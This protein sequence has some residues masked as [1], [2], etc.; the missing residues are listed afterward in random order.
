MRFD[1]V[2]LRLFVHLANTLNLTRAAERSH[3]SLS[4]ASA[5]IKHLE[6]NV[7][8]K[9]IYRHNLGVTLTPQGETFLQHARQI[10]QQCEQLN[11]DMQEY[12]RGMKGHLRLYA[13]MNASAAFVPDLLRQLLEKHPRISIDLQER[14][15][16]QEIIEAVTNGLADVGLL[17]SGLHTGNLEVLSYRPDPIVVAVPKG[18]RF[19]SRQMIAFE[20]AL[21]ED[22]IALPGNRFIDAFLRSHGCEKRMRIRVA[23]GSYDTVCRLIERNV[24]IGVLPASAATRR[25]SDLAIHIVSLTN[26]WADSELRICARSFEQ[27]PVFARDLVDIVTTEARFIRRQSEPAA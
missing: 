2:D 12:S 22:F 6:D 19:A 9:L 14:S 5:R 26:E 23:A 3:M 16:S 15:M 13:N 7:G 4:A 11:V 17:S 18:H 20:E 1:F 8:S 27:L 10:L 21:D 25:A 24:G